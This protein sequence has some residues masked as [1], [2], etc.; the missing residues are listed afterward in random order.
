M[1]A[2]FLIP[3][4]TLLVA[5]LGDKTQLAVVSLTTKT[6]KHFLLFVS[7][8][9]AFLITDGLAIYFGD[10][11]LNNINIYIVKIISG[12]LFLSIGLYG[13][14]KYKKRNKEKSSLKKYVS[15]IFVNGFILIFFAEL[16]DKSQISAMLFSGLYNNYLVFLGVMSALILVSLIG[17]YFGKVLLQYFSLK[18]VEKISNWVF[19]LI[20]L[21][22]LGSLI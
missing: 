13:I 17:I 15:N 10:W 3:F 6:K 18:K 20:G 9:L 1:I 8:M 22:T 11:I 12:I 14:L 4:G 19:I 21:M 16:G 5:E 2:D 7:V